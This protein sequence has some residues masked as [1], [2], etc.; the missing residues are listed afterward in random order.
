MIQARAPQAPPSTPP[1]TT[2]PPAAPG[3]TSVTPADL[4]ARNVGALRARAGV[5]LDQLTSATNRRN[6]LERQLERATGVN[7]TGI[8]QHLAQLDA[9]ILR[10]E[11][12]ID[13][14][15]KVLASIPA[16]TAST[17]PALIPGTRRIDVNGI[18]DKIVPLVA[19][20]TLFVLMPI[21]L[22]ISRGIWRRTSSPKAPPQS[23]DDAQR[24]ERIE[25]AIDSI[26]LEVERVSEGQRFVTRILAE[27]RPGGALAQNVGQPVPIPRMEGVDRR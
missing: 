19:I 9:R 23:R 5:L 7:K 2:P 24:L 25:H 11:A 27:G 13:E 15:G 14:N 6:N 8:E 4:T 3:V 22:S 17:A 18:V 20:V 12:D 21:A 26:A 1:A 10:L 16:Q